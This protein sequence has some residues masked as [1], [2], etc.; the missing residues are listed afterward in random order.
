MKNTVQEAPLEKLAAFA[1]SL[2]WDRLPKEVQQAAAFRALDL[3]SVAMGAV[4]DPLVENM[5]E[6]LRA[7]DPQLRREGVTLWGQTLGEKWAVTEA[8]MLDAMLA[9]TLELDDVHPASKTHLSASMIPAAWCLARQLGRSGKEFLTALVAGYEVGHRVGMT[10][11]VA[12][13]RKRGWHAT[14]TCGPLPWRR[15]VPICCGWMP[16]RRL[17]PSAWPVPRPRVYGPFWGT[18]PIPRC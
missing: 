7:L 1:A 10:L 9:H 13:H 15:P 18:A 5:K 14:A 2:S 6:A 3:V 11:G 17:R 12:A 16:G 4:G 8:A